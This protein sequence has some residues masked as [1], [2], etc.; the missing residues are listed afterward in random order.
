MIEA[1]FAHDGEDSISIKLS[2]PVV[3][4]R[5]IAFNGFYASTAGGGY[6]LQGVSTTEGNTGDV[7]TACTEYSYPVEMAEPIPLYA[8][9][10]PAADGSGRAAVGTATNNCGTCLAV[11]ATQILLKIERQTH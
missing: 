3:P 2:Q 1:E 8:Y 11:G 7:I 9:V 6:D 4:Y 5:L 10:K